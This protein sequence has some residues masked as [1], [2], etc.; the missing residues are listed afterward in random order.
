MVTLLLGYGA[1]PS[2][3]DLHGDTP[4]HIG[5]E[6]GD[7]EAITLLLRVTSQAPLICNDWGQTPLR[8]AVQ[9]LN[10]NIVRELLPISSRSELNTQDEN[11]WTHMHTLVYATQADTFGTLKGCAR[12]TTIAMLLSDA[13]I[14]LSLRGSSGQTAL[15]IAAQS[16][17]KITEVLVENNADQSDIID[18]YGCT[19]CESAREQLCERRDKQQKIVKKK[20]QITS[21]AAFR[22]QG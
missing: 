8:L 21:L 17:L 13:G 18:E 5:V 12:K 7:L 9:L 16:G 6:N 14:D 15:Q 4:L 22:A 11:G 10:L 2:V 1:T 19:A 3:Q 20:L